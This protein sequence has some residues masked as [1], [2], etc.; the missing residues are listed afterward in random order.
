[1]PVA[2]AS[3]KDWHKDSFWYSPW[4]SSGVHKGI[5][6]FAA[7]G[8][9][10]VATSHLW[11]LF[12]GEFSKG[13]KMVL[14]LGPK[15]RLHYFAHLDV[16]EPDLATWLSAGTPIGTVGDSGNALGKPAHLHYSIVS[17]VPQFAA[18]DNTEQGHKKAFYLNP[19]RY[20]AG[21]D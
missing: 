6:I 19:S 12:K 15:W 16:I 1:M 4:G 3:A 20:L 10:V 5:D 11:V 7:K 9:P 14:A 13:G 18:I 8:T 21:V 2:G 17:L